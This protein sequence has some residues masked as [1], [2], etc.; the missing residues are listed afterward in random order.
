M[1][2]SA[3]E[4]FAMV[5]GAVVAA[6][7]ASRIAFGSPFARCDSGTTRNSISDFGGLD[8]VFGFFGNPNL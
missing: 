8:L 2:S 6:E 7:E 4:T 5:L 1:K 3:D